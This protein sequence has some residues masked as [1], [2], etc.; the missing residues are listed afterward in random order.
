MITTIKEAWFSNVPKDVLSGVLVALALIPEAIA[1]SIIAGVDPMVGLYAS[2]C[3]AVVI[4]FAGGRPA[5]ISAATGAM[6][7]VMGSLVA[8]HG[9][10]YL[11][12]T[13]ILTGL[14]QIFFGVFKVARLM[15]FIPRP[16]MIGFVNSLA[17]LIFIAQLVHFEGES[18]QIYAFVAGAL[19]IIYVLPRFVKA[20]PSPLVAIVVMTI[21]AALTHSSTKTVGDMGELKQ[22]LPSFFIPD[23]PFNM[24]TLQIIFPYAIALAIV[25]LME[26]FLTAQ[27]LDDYTDTN[28]N[29]NREARGQGIANIAAGFF[30]GMAGC[31]M[32]GQS[33]INVKAGGRTR[34]STFIAGAFLM[35]LIIVFND[36]MVQIPMGALV[37]VM[38]MVSIGTF[39]WSSVRNLHRMPLTDA[40]VMIVTVAA[41]LWT[42][43]LSVGVIIGVLMS[44]VFFAAKISKVDVKGTKQEG[45]KVYMV[46]G[47]LFFVSVTDFLASFDPKR[48]DT[49]QIILDFQEARLWDDSAVGALDKLVL[50][51]REY[52]IQVDVRNLD[53]ASQALVDRRAAYIQ[54]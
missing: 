8:D 18:W 53:H 5:M 36:V 19:V 41:V 25:G 12:A 15:I 23:V 30:G 47:Q 38:F 43:N 29:K 6:A 26:T 11:F 51:Y 50:K 37:A 14:I 34:L 4:A 49:Q 45:Q 31:A 20:I 13:T 21:I 10:Q 28:S 22:A 48:E 54:V 7:L 1:F 27:L 33:V 42:H 52:G 9:L 24:E 32:I 40:A 35:L 3:I 44:A 17:I 2:F 16:V 39:D 46:K